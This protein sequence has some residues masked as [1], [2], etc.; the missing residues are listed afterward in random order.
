MIRK[1]AVALVLGTLASAPAWAA[2]S[3]SIDKGH[4]EAG[5]QIRHLVSKVHGRFKDFEGVIQVDREKPEASTVSFSVKTA[6]IDTDNA[7]RD[8]DL[9]SPNFFETDKFPQMT[10]QSS[11]IVAKDKDHFDVTGT[12][13]LHGVSKEVTVA[14]AV[15]GFAK[16]PWGGERAGF[17]VSTTLNRKDFGLLWNKTLD[18]GGLLVG[19]DV[20]VQIAI[21]A[22]KK[23]PGK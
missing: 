6:S 2:E 12:L 9:R 1:T 15:G 11:K 20:Q 18:S 19:D 10:F 22:V 23:A 4:S 16:D 21:E 13:S 17:D 5:F 14:V 8:K 7:D 3:Y